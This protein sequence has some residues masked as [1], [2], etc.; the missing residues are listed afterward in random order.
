M[1]GVYANAARE[2]ASNESLRGLGNYVRMEILE[3]R[4]RKGK[5]ARGKTIHINQPAI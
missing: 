5:K 3:T 2:E 1:L 4:L